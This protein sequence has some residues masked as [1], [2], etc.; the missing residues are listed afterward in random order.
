MTE[1]WTPEGAEGPEFKSSA[2]GGSGE[3]RG[4]RT[5]DGEHEVSERINWI[6]KIQIYP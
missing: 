2:S 3:G 1:D 4:L 5:K 6:K